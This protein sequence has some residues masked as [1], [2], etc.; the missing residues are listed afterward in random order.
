MCEERER[1][2]GEKGKSVDPLLYSFS[3]TPGL[4]DMYGQLFRQSVKYRISCSRNSVSLSVVSPAVLPQDTQASIVPLRVGAV[5]ARH[6]GNHYGVSN[7]RSLVGKSFASRFA[8]RFASFGVRA[9][10]NTISSVA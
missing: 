6:L 5:A 10:F 4:T 9:G 1:E 2:L 7:H 8:S 3:N